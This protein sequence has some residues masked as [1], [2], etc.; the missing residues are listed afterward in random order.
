MMH[1]D[2]PDKLEDHWI[3][4]NIMVIFLAGKS[5][6]KRTVIIISPLVLF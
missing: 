3:V 2:D 6:I 5:L 4:A 1:P